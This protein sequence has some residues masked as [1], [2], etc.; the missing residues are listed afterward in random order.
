[1]RY[2]IRAV[3]VGALALCAT[4]ASADPGAKVTSTQGFVVVMR[5][6]STL[7]LG[8]GDTIRSG[9]RV[10]SG[11]AS[12]VSFSSGASLGP[13]MSG[14]ARTGA[15]DLQITSKVGGKTSSTSGQSQSSSRSNL[16]SD[17]V[18]YRDNDRNNGHSDRDD[19]RD[20]DRDGDRD[21]KNDRN[22]DKGGDGKHDDDYH[23]RGHDHHDNGHD[24]DHPWRGNPKDPDSCSS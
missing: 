14:L 7:R 4:I 3:A 18:S 8:E 2:L 5:G 20:R 24:D 19:Y 22:R 11:P 9:D 23:D 6:N 21:D 10:F 12:A 16:F 17:K 13:G 1:M 15:G